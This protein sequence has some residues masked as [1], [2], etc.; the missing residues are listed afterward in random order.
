MMESELRRRCDLDHI[1]Q[2]LEI[3]ELIRPHT[4]LGEIKGSIMSALREINDDIGKEIAEAKAKPL[5]K[6]ALPEVRSNQEDSA[7]K[8]TAPIFPAG[9]G[10]EETGT[11]QRITPVPEDQRG[12]LPKYS[13]EVEAPPAEE[14]QR[15]LV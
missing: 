5:P 4:H 13:G 6:A 9:S 7:P 15:R 8:Y 10:V 14:T 1:Q 3:E 2:L 12:L 11:Q